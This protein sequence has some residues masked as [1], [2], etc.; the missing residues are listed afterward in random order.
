MSCPVVDCHL[1][2]ILV[3][4]PFLVFL[5]SILNLSEV[6]LHDFDP[7]ALVLVAGFVPLD[8]V[9]CVLD[10][11]LELLLLVIEL[12]LESQ[13]VF[14]ERNAIAKK[15]FIA[16]GLVFLVYL[17]VFEEFNAGLHGGDLLV[18]VQNDVIVYLTLLTFIFPPGLQ[19][20]DFVSGLC[21]L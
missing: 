21:Q 18:E 13:E 17:L 2:E 19:L 4:R 14:I 7:V 1:R 12:V 8:I 15:R 11:C 6:I 3:I 5:E 9:F 16:T 20:F 10:A